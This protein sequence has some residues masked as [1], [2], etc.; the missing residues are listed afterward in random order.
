VEEIMIPLQQLRWVSPDQEIVKILEF[1]DREDINQVPV[2]EQGRLLGMVGRQEILH[3][4]QRRLDVS[5]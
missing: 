1:M 2:V 5:A 3:L 4:L